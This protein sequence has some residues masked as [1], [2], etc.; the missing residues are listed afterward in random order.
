[1]TQAGSVVTSDRNLN[2]TFYQFRNL[3]LAVADGPHF[4]FVDLVFRTRVWR[5]MELA[6]T[7]A[8]CLVRIEFK[9]P[10]Y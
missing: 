9:T 4:S 10:D 3:H 6:F 1:M 8:D 5:S 7:C 2:V